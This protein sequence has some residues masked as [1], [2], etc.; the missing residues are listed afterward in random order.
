MQTKMTL[1][2]HLKPIRSSK[3]PV[4]T[5]AGQDVEQVKHSSISGGSGNLYSQ[6]LKSIWQFLRKLGLNLPQDQAIPLLGLNPKDSL[7]IPQR[8]FLNYVHSS[9]ICNN[10]KL[11]EAN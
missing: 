1:R 2:F 10:Q 8:H 7:P 3:I 9:F 4:T 6:F 11:L 5:F